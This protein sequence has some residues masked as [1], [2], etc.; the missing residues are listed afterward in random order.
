MWVNGRFTDTYME[1]NKNKTEIGN[2]K[3]MLDNAGSH[4]RLRDDFIIDKAMLEAARKQFCL[5]TCL[6]WQ[7]YLEQPNRKCYIQKTNYAA[8]TTYPV[9]QGARRYAGMDSFFKAIMCM[10]QLF[11]A[12]DEQIYD[13]AVEK[14]SD[15]AP[16]WFCQYGNLRMIDEKL[17]EYGRKIN[18]THV[19]FLPSMSGQEAEL[20]QTRERRDGTFPVRWYEQEEILQ[21][22]EKNAFT[23]AIC[24]S[25]T[26]PDVLAVAAFCA[27]E[28]A[29]LGT[30]VH[31]CSCEE[32]CCEQ[33][34]CVK[35]MEY[36]QTKMMGMAG[37]SA[38]GEY[39][40]QI[41]I[42]VRPQYARRGL[43]ANLVRQIKEEIIRRGKI[44]FYG[45]SESHT[46]SQTVALKSGFVPAWTEI[47]VK[48]I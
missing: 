18:D 2:T 44:P 13:W 4:K 32:C 42:N 21:F 7:Q 27:G 43:A 3:V 23:S 20:E 48:G 37:A 45:T 39:L 31:Y 16:E 8:G 29:T 40:W 38:D 22:K 47:Y 36:D 1:V 11:L 46:V 19:Y 30:P 5:D 24:F 9:A 17:Q 28:D 6:D 25:P 41:G 35:D 15:C 33:L 34:H 14:F 26:Q 12:V 10:G